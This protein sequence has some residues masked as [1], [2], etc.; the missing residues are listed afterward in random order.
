MQVRVL[1]SGAG[2][3]LPQWNC[4]CDNCHAARRGEIP[5]RTQ[6]SVAVSS[7]GESWFLL[8]ASPDILAQIANAPELHP[9]QERG[10]PIAGVVLPNGDVDS[11]VGLFS[12]RENEP[13]SVYSTRSV[14]SGLAER[15]VLMRT[16][17]RFEGHLQVHSLELD[18]P[19]QLRRSDGSPSGLSVRLVA[20][21][22]KEPLHL[23][24]LVSPAEEHST[25]VLVNDRSSGR[26]LAF[27]PSVGGPSP[28]LEGALREA[29][30]ILF[31]GTFWTSDELSSR[32]MARRSAEQMGH[33][34]LSGPEG[35]LAFLQRLPGRSLLVH[36][37]N[38]NPLLRPG[39]ERAAL[40]ETGIALT[41]DGLSLRP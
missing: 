30:L 38:T 20:V 3:G 32:G 14:W 4:N 10:S 37:N 12:L 31:D 2:G 33:W 34:P 13:I 41:H 24:G 15:N 25:G 1:G 36:V 39:P 26:T 7:D 29:H 17:Q 19:H 16:L 8:S 6:A 35:S 18:Q 5:A 27:F 11:C 23:E 40:D 22:G 28:K 21:R 9:R